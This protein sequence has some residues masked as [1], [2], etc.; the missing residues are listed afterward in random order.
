MEFSDVAFRVLS[1]DYVKGDSGTGVVHC[2]PAFGEDDYRVCLANEIIKKGEGL[3][4][5]V[6]ENGCFTERVADFSNLYVKEADK[7][8]IEAVRLKGRPV[9]SGT[10]THSSPFCWRTNTPL[11][12]RAVPSWFIRV[13]Q[14][15]EKLLENN[16]QTYWVP[17]FVKEKRFHNWLENARDWAVSRS[18]FWGTPLPVWVSED[19]EEVLVMDSIEKL[20]KL[21]GVKVSDLHRHYIDHI[22]IPSARGP[23]FGYLRRVDDVFDCWFESGSMPYAYIHYP[24]ENVELFEK[25]LPGN[26]VAEGLDQTRGWFY[27]LMV[28]STALFGKPAAFKNLICNGLVLADDGK[29]FLKLSSSYGG[30][31]SIWG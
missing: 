3:I 29:K 18:R 26:F 11:I 28:L 13:E 15:K 22:T 7:A 19:G 9:K 5:P 31:R 17:D 25:N 12:Y 21:S 2:A 1:D 23:E 14:L 8:I 24:F 4:V 6:D 10:I 27:T 20:E 30:S 16:K